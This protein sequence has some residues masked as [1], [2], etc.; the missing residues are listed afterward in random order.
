MSR[1]KG[2]KQHRELSDLANALRAVLGMD[3]LFQDGRKAKRQ[4]FQTAERFVLV[5]RNLP[6]AQPVRVGYQR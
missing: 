4:S 3:P 6:P 2:A 1:P 5:A